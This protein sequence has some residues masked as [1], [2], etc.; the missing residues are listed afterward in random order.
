MRRPLRAVS[1]A[2][3]LVG[4]AL[5][6][7]AADLDG[8]MHAIGVTPA[9]LKP[10]PAFRLTTLEGSMAALTDHRGRPV[11]LYFLGDVVTALHEGVALERRADVPRSVWPRAVGPGVQGGPG[12][13][14]GRGE[15]LSPQEP[16]R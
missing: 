5:G 15:P 13:A 3:L 14:G 11:L 10:A 2:L 4:V 8:L 7:P 1:L 9:G 16:W 12:A 6:A